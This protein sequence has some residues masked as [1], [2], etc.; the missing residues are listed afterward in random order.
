M[1]R[2]VGF[3]S[4]LWYILS[5][6]PVQNP[7][8]NSCSVRITSIISQSSITNAISL[9]WGLGTNEER[10]LDSLT[11]FN[12]LFLVFPLRTIDCCSVHITISFLCLAP[13]AKTSLPERWFDH[14][15]IDFPR[16]NPNPANLPCQKASQ[17]FACRPNE[18]RE[19]DR[20]CPRIHPY[21]QKLKHG[22]Q[23]ADS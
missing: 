12:S 10:K 21:V 20:E 9:T 16:H 13:Y 5:H 1:D 23:H 19:K 18:N 3:L 7:M 15:S 2:E 14:P 17:T 8:I 6:R 11:F 4:I 22:F